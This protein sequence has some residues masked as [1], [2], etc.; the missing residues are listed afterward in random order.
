MS[1][2]QLRTISA[3]VL[4]AVTLWLTW[5]GGLPFRFLAAA[6]GAGI[7]YEWVAITAIRQTQLSK[8]FGWL[9]LALV[10][11]MLLLDESAYV[12]FPVLIGAAII[13][14]IISSRTGGFWPALG[15]IY[16]ALPAIAL[17]LLR[18]DDADGLIAII[19]LFAV[20][21]ATDI[22]AYFNGRALGGPKLAPKLSP[23]KTWSGALGGAAAAVAAG[24]CVGAVAGAASGW[25]IPV[26][27]LFLSIA[28]QFGDIGESWVKRIF[29]VKDSG[30]IIPGHGGV[31]DRV[32]GLV[33]A[34]TVLYLLGAVLAGAD[35]PSDIYL[36]L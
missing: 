30:K 7:F 9:S 28:S 12:I 27:A 19:F 22:F 15:L 16:A 26:I 32:D 18:G 2:L 13:L 23:N 14:Y 5:L 24:I 36:A 33:I 6:I 34:A 25:M 11:S 35:A 17:G 20:V 1:N 31:M 29:G 21:W 8:L 4:G 10:L 3:I